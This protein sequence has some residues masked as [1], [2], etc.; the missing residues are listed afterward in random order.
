MHFAA[1]NG[2]LS[3]IPEKFKTAE[4][5]NIPNKA[6]ETVFHLCGVRGCWAGLPESVITL[7]A[8]TR[9]DLGGSNPLHHFGESLFELDDDD[10]VEQ[11]SSGFLSKVPKCALYP[12]ALMQPNGDG[13]TPL[14]IFVD[15]LRC[16]LKYLLGVELPEEARDLV[17]DAWFNANLEVC[18][19][20]KRSN[21]TVEVISDAESV[22]VDI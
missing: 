18:L 20:K 9:L 10:A 13:I 21:G 19:E 16:D 7:D 22:E 14:K 2:Y 6:G 4:L 5:L 17:G 1:E 12:E 3:S 8:M 15:D 11:A